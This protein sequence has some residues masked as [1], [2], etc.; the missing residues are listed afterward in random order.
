MSVAELTAVLHKEPG[1]ACGF[2]LVKNS[3]TVNKIVDNVSDELRPGDLILR[4]NDI[5]VSDDTIREIL[6]NCRDLTEVHVTVAR[7]AFNPKRFN[8]QARMLGIMDE[9]PKAKSG[10]CFRRNKENVQQVGRRRESVSSYSPRGI[11]SVTS[12]SSAGMRPVDLR[13]IQGTM[14]KASRE[15]SGYNSG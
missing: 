3:C 10:C 15:S 12:L 8:D 2:T 5:E 1:A 14:W 6:R 11:G 13:K 7:T 4:I 9:S